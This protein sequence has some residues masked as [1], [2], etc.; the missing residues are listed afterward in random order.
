MEECPL[1]LNIGA[2]SFLNHILMFLLIIH[3]E[4]FSAM[5]LE[6]Y[7][8]LLHFKLSTPCT[9]IK[10]RGNRNTYKDKN[11]L[12]SQ[13]KLTGSTSAFFSYSFFIISVYKKIY[14]LRK[15][16]LTEHVNDIR[17][18]KGFHKICGQIIILK[19]IPNF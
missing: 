8:C 12:I 9:Y 17:Y 13:E 15:H 3:I 19:K 5:K 2:L 1:L 4:L 11:Q 16:T 6:G 10:G 7:L 18:K 14:L